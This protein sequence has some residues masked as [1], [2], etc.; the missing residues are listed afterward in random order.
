MSEFNSYNELEIILTDEDYNNHFVNNSV[1]LLSSPIPLV[2]LVFPGT[3]IDLRPGK[4]RVICSLTYQ[5]FETGVTK[6]SKVLRKYVDAGHYFE[7]IYILGTTEAALDMGGNFLGFI[8]RILRFTRSRCPDTKFIFM[9]GDM[10]AKRNVR[11]Y[12]ELNNIDFAHID[13]C[14]FPFGLLSRTRRRLTRLNQ[15]DITMDYNSPTAKHFI[16]MNA[17][18]NH[19]R[20]KLL[21]NLHETNVI[22]KCYW[23]WLR[24]HADEDNDMVLQDISRGFFDFRQ[25]K[26]LDLT[27]GQL[28]FEDNQDTVDN[29]YYLTDSL[30]DIGVETDARYQ[31]ITEKTWKPLL[32]GKVSLFLQGEN[33]HSDVLTSLGFEL[34]DE[35]FDYSFDK[36]SDEWYRFR[37]YCKEL[38]RVSEIPIEELQKKIISI[39]DKITRNRNHAWNCDILVHPLFKE[40]PT[41]L[42]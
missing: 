24:R 32:Y 29:F 26:E 3:I 38:K 19:S 23:S 4:K 13:C 36:I 2:L 42:P 21:D 1:L 12:T 25:T 9:N 30:I 15:G 39:E 40:Y 35:I 37:A 8:E 28:E 33:Y 20:L 10:N 14:G 31:F 11:E 17:S 34:Y 18:E 16:C 22:D 41:L 7:Q 6:L 5:G 27:L